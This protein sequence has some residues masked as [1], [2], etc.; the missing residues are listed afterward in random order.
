[1]KGLEK[2]GK[3]HPSVPVCRA[4]EALP[5]LVLMVVAVLLLLLVPLLLLAALPKVGRGGIGR[6]LH[7]MF[8]HLASNLSC[9][10]QPAMSGTRLCGRHN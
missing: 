1:M 2:E 8:L 7:V 4:R 9:E 5:P 10:G 6:V 3:V